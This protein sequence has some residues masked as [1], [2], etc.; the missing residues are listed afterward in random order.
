MAGEEWTGG[1]MCGAVRFRAQGSP[2]R[3][4]IC[5][6]RTC[7]KATGSAFA[8][9]VLFAGDQVVIESGETIR[10]VS[11]ETV[12]RHSC[13]GCGSPVFDTFTH[14]DNIDFHLG[15][16]DQAERL[17]PQ[18]EVWTARRLPWVSRAPGTT[19][20]RFGNPD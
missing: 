14:S 5:H 10:F 4:E 1:C 15:A 16:L 13:G 6:C 20:H 17:V 11:S 2:I 8:V 19:C 7:R 9:F 3:V 12:I 18:R